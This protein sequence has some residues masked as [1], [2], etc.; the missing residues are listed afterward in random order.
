MRKSSVFM[1][2]AL[3]AIDPTT[4][5]QERCHTFEFYRALRPMNRLHRQLWLVRDDL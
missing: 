3:L 4:L 5:R 1:D 2:H